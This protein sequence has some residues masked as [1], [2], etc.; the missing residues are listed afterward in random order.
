MVFI[1]SP[2]LSLFG[3]G[4]EKKPRPLNMLPIL[5]KVCKTS[6]RNKIIKIIMQFNYLFHGKIIPNN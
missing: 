4:T 6:D 3:F 5:F 2:L 1:S